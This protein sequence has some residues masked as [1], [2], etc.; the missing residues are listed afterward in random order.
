M[1]TGRS[2]AE[3]VKNKCYD[4]LCQAAQNYVDNDWQSLDLYARRVHKIG[5]VEFIDAEIKRVYVRDLPGMAVAFE[6]G[7]ELEI[8]VKEGNH[9]YDESDVCYPW[10]RISCEGDISCG[11]DDWKIVSI[12]PYNPKNA[13]ANSLSDALVPYIPYDKLEDEATKFLNEFYPEALKITSYVQKPVVVEPDIIAERLGLNIMMQRIREDSF[14]FGQLY[15]E[16]TDAEMYDA[17]TGDS[18]TKHIPEKTIVVDPYMF[19]LRTIGSVNNTIIHECVHW[20]KHRKVFELEKLYN[21]DVSCISCEVVGGAAAAIAKQAT[22]MME[23]QANQL[24]PRIQMPAL[25]FKA[26]A[27]EYIIKFARETGARH[28][29]EIMENVIEALG[30]DFVVSKQAVK[31]RLVELGFDQ[32]IGT[33]TYLDG[34]YVKPHGFKKGSIKTN[35]TFSISSRDAAVERFLNR[36]LRDLTDSGDYLFIDNHF[37]YNAPLYVKKDEYGRL[38]LTDYARSHMDECCIVFDMKITSKVGVDYHT[39]CYL[40]R[41]D[42]NITFEIKYHNGFQNAPKERQVAMRKKQQEEEI[43]IRKQMTDDPEHCMDLLLKW[44]K[45]KYTDLGDAIDRDPK[46]IR[47]TVKGETKP[48]VETAVLIC[49]GLH[50]PP[51]ISMKLIESLGVKLSPINPDHQWMNEVLHTKYPESVDAVRE[52]L[53][54]Y[55]VE[56]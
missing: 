14:V 34:H 1:A 38:N 35:Q 42:S 11:L 18:A 30:T 32:A 19:L 5:E 6:V 56:I 43:E 13:P 53:A 4:G 47:R 37:V 49:I 26:K 21:N 15:F 46:T 44:R 27:K 50:L 39:A 25:P 9:H 7:L 51:S 10:V 45:M 24:A 17:S 22:K 2:F 52:Y 31:I 54:P 48:K 55:D 29:N 41:E 40:N 12:A 23:R 3:Y 20:V 36:E 16:D 28:D 33:Y 8:E